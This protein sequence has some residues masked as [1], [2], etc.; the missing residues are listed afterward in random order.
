MASLRAAYLRGE[1]VMALLDAGS[2]QP[3]RGFAAI[4]TSYDL[5]AG[6]YTAAFETPEGARLKSAFA[7]ALVPHIEGY[8]TLLDAGVGEATTLAPVFERLESEV[9]IYGFDASVSR[10]LWARRN[11]AAVGGGDHGSSLPTRL[12]FRSG[13]LALIW[14]FLC[15]VSS[16]TEEARLNYSPNSSASLRAG[17]F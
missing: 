8:E 13:I 7:E 16:P 12:R 1:N 3:S 10:L 5:Q 15:T 17:W 11:L 2:G 14:S 6:S 4:Q 9:E